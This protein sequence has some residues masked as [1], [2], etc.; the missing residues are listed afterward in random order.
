MGFIPCCYVYCKH[1]MIWQPIVVL[2]PQ[3]IPDED[4]AASEVKEFVAL[5]CSEKKLLH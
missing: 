1:A 5:E 2:D 4:K 3:C